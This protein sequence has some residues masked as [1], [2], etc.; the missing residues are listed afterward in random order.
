MVIIEPKTSHDRWV[1]P[2]VNARA[3][4]DEGLLQPWPD[5]DMRYFQITKGFDHGVS[6]EELLKPIS[7]PIDL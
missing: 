1:K 2:I 4:L 5:E 7:N 3:F 6:D